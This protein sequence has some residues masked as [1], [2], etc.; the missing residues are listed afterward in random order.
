MVENKKPKLKSSLS[1][2]LLILFLLVS[3]IVL[4]FPM[5]ESIESDVSV[6]SIWIHD[7]LIASKTFE[8]LK[9]PETYNK[10][11]QEAA[12]KVYQIFV[13]HKDALDTTLDSVKNFNKVLIRK[14]DESI[15][16][17]NNDE[18][19][20]TFLSKDSFLYFLQLRK[21]E[22]LFVTKGK[23]SFNEVIGFI[24]DIIKKVYQR[25]YIDQTYNQIKKDS[26]ALR[27]GKFERVVP[28][29]VYLDSNSLR[30]FIDLYIRNYFGNN[31]KVVN[32]IT[33]Y[34][35]N[36]LKPNV[37]YDSKLTDLAVRSAMDKVSKNI[38]IVNQNE[39]IVA[40]HDRITP[41][42]KQKI[43]SYRV[44]KGEEIGFWGRFAQSIGKYFHI[45]I[46]L[47]LYIIYIYLFRKKIFLDNFKLLLISMI[48]LFISFLT[49]IILQLNVKAPVEFFV[50]VPVA[51][52]LLTIIFD[53]RVGFYGT[54]VVALVCGGL[55]GND[56]VFSVMNI[57]A[58][59]L[60]AY[61]VRDI[62]NRTQ[63]FRSFSFILIGYVIGIISFGL[64]RFDSIQNM[65]VSSA[66]ATASALLSP[67]FTYGFI[68]F[69]EKFFGITT[70][71]TLLELTDLNSPLLREL[72]RSAPGTFTHSM[73]MGTL[74]E[75][76]AEAIGANPTLARVGAYYHD[77]GKI[78][79]PSGFVEN[80][81]DN[82]N[83][84]DNLSP[85]E[86]VQI[87]LEHVEKGVTLAKQY[88]LPQEI[89]DF[90]PMHHGTIVISFFYE[91]AK[92]LYGENNV[93]VNYYSYKGPK[94]NTKETALVMLADACESTVRSMNDAD[95]QKVENVINNIINNRLNEGQLDDSP[96]T[97]RD[98]KKIKES[99]LSI[100]IGQHHKRIRYP[101]QAEIENK[102]DST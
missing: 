37:I 26:I 54:I 61:T 66:F 72:A 60:A 93:D 74:V 18:A 9:D 70:D 91:K 5:G 94:P 17:K 34:L 55:R 40:K 7:D 84:H 95:S 44:A 98:I 30:D 89:I 24:E 10:E 43:D 45:L 11:R 83:I 71:L 22:N 3:L 85:E 15:K 63:I 52:M 68:I 16:L 47:S 6:G 53:S 25:G 96:L 41:E 77:I 19:N 50:L 4:M 86:S 38:G 62:K 1:I 69:I 14:L 75:S 49:Y 56:Y 76:A 28:K 100:L 81:L 32:A 23:M 35:D 92:K 2:K 42:I 51:S 31:E 29:R 82:K 46:I 12:S 87:I 67:V 13:L 48:I 57:F 99:F 33:E 21:K 64:E 102:N 20:S 80:Q 36:F 79:N 73:T 101:N 39:R 78:L 97:F 65:L 58:G 27:D 88:N 8:I 59:A 90:I